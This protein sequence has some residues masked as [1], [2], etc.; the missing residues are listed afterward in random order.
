MRIALITPQFK[1]GGAE[2]VMSIMARN[3]SRSH[4]VHLVFHVVHDPFYSI[5][6]SVTVHYVDSIRPHAP[7]SSKL[8]G[9]LGGLLRLRRV[10]RRTRPD[11][12]VSFN[13]YRYDHVVILAKMLLRIPIVVSERSNPV[14]YGVVGRALRWVVYSMADAIVVQT[15]YA[16]QYYE[17]RFHRAKIELIPNPVSV[18]PSLPASREPVVLHV[19][20]FIPDKGQAHLIRAFARLKLDDWRLILVGDGPLAGAMK[21]LA[22][23]LGVRQQVVFPGVVKDVGRYLQTAAIFVLPSLREGFPNALAEAMAAGI[24]C[25]SFNCNAGPGE[26]IN[27]GV[28]GFL[29]EPNDIDGLTEK[30][31]LLVGD[32]KL[33]TNLGTRARKVATRFSE[34]Q[35]MAEWERL[36]GSLSCHA[37]GSMSVEYGRTP[38]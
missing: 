10:L 19:G 33:R 26:L 13:E 28:N 22:A 6:G 18:F 35:V 32:E 14:R 5:P 21:D 34:D 12:I 27:D 2:R 1:S 16:R 15:E 9:Y 36:V 11:V 24:P 8:S 17:R 23:Y 30:I 31:R 4:E 37:R 3:L 29:V 20:R 25:V 38:S 7:F